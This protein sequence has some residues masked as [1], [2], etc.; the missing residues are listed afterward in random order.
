MYYIALRSDRFTINSINLSS[1]IDSKNILFMW[2]LLLLLFTLT[3]AAAVA[4]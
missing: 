3:A 4:F 2:L 1:A